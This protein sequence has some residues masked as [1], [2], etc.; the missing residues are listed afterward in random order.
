ML[1]IDN[2]LH[3]IGKSVVTLLYGLD[4]PFCR[5]KLLLHE[6]CRF[7]LLPFGRIG[8]IHKYISIFPVDTQFRKRKTWH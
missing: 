4:E 5:I 3:G 8:R 2:S 1:V 7:L 6:S